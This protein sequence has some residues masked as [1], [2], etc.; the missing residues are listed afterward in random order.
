MESPLYPASSYPTKSIPTTH[1]NYKS[2]SLII[3]EGIKK[4]QENSNIYNSS[5]STLKKKEN[6]SSNGIILLNDST[7]TY[8]YNNNN[9]T[10]TNWDNIHNKSKSIHQP[11]TVKGV[12]KL[13]FLNKNS[14]HRTKSVDS[15]TN[16]NSILRKDIFAISPTNSLKSVKSLKSLSERFLETDSMVIVREE[17]KSENITSTTHESSSNSKKKKSKFFSFFTKKCSTRKVINDS[18]DDIVDS[19][20]KNEINNNIKDKKNNDYKI[21]D[22]QKETFSSLKNTFKGS[23]A[24]LKFNS[25]KKFPAPNPP[26]TIEILK[27]EL[28]NNNHNKSKENNLS[29][30]MPN[31]NEIPPTLSVINNNIMTTTPEPELSPPMMITKFKSIFEDSK[32]KYQST[33][34]LR[35]NNNDDLIVCTLTNKEYK[36]EEDEIVI[37]LDMDK[38]DKFLKADPYTSYNNKGGFNEMNGGGRMISNTYGTTT[39]GGE[40]RNNYNNKEELYIKDSSDELVREYNKLKILYEKLKKSVDST[41]EL[42]SQRSFNL[43]ASIIEQH[44]VVKKLCEQVK[45]EKELKEKKVTGGEMSPMINTKNNY[46]ENNGYSIDRDGRVTN[47]SRFGTPAQSPLMN[48]YGKRSTNSTTIRIDTFHMDTYSSN[49]SLHNSNNSRMYEYIDK[50]I[51]NGILYDNN[52][53]IRNY[54]NTSTINNDNDKISKIWLGEEKNNSKRYDNND[55]YNYKNN[56]K[57]PKTNYNRM[58]EELKAQIEREKEFEEER[59]LVTNIQ[60]SNDKIVLV[61]KNNITSPVTDKKVITNLSKTSPQNN[62]IINLTTTTNNRSYNNSP[63]IG[64]SSGSLNKTLYQQIPRRELIILKSQPSSPKI[65]E[66]K[67]ININKDE[68]NFFQLDDKESVI[69]QMKNTLRKVSPPIEKTGMTLGRV[70]E[71]NETTTT[72]SKLSPSSKNSESGI[73]SDSSPSTSPLPPPPLFNGYGNKTFKEVNNDSNKPKN[74]PPPPPPSFGGKNMVNNGKIN[75]QNFKTDSTNRNDLLAE[76]RKFGGASRLKKQ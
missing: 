33:P 32:S 28:Y 63:K 60:K 39:S 68:K 47:G 7:K 29:L 45:L 50:T 43:Q 49:T 2:T 46:F 66:H 54:N 26:S 57:V 13:N 58:E 23:L 72:A 70:I 36:M 20:K 48:D 59:K 73:S 25:K 18:N 17:V 21:N 10:I 55:Y 16:N 12:K 64:I 4:N 51:N 37:K 41:Q 15:S 6:L 35:D 69:N 52:R 19:L 3:G 75:N 8:I 14:L 40:I 76:I 74:P 27:K 24:S 5:K 61:K 53:T 71:N 34:D 56:E 11:R 1:P 42:T 65:N 67:K 31:V 38:V 9:N 62:A 22:N 30:S 44:N